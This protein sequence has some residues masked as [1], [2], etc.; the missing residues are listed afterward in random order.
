MVPVRSVSS[1]AAIRR[2][3]SWKIADL[4][5]SELD[6][7]GAQRRAAPARQAP[8]LVSAKKIDDNFIGSHHFKRAPLSAPVI[9][10]DVEEEPSNDQGAIEGEDPQVVIGSS[11]GA[12]EGPL[13]TTSLFSPSLLHA[14]VSDGSSPRLFP[15][16]TWSISSHDA[17]SAGAVTPTDVPLFYLGA[18]TSN[19]D[20]S[21][22]DGAFGII[23][24]GQ[25]VDTLSPLA[26]VAVPPAAD[27][28]TLDTF[29]FRENSGRSLDSAPDGEYGN[30][31][32]PFVRRFP[33][34]ADAV[35]PSREVDASFT[36]LR[37]PFASTGAAGFPPGVYAPYF[38]PP[39]DP[40]RDHVLSPYGFTPFSTRYNP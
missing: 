2:L 33:S 17:Y 22:E 14:P 1:D 7:F 13:A 35:Y 40:C 11:Y 18:F 27:G 9:E 3:I 23:E 20:D 37:H 29:S 32:S 34:L 4:Q 21:I 15:G 8:P 30:S 25:E 28:G 24:A 5:P 12:Y 36:L 19:L 31:T 39:F 10:T 26:S 38:P 6:L 16:Q